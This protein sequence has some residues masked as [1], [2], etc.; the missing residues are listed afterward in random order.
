MSSSGV[1]LS[2]EKNKAM[3]LSING[4]TTP[5]NKSKMFVQS[6]ETILSVYAEKWD[7]L[8]EFMEARHG[9][10]S[11]TISGHLTE[12]GKGAQKY[13]GGG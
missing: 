10:I 3:A 4:V 8:L 12:K 6:A 11:Y 9:E 7:E 1:A 13:G 2:K 5:K